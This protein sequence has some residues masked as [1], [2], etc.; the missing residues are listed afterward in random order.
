MM[1]ED[2]KKKTKDVDAIF[3]NELT[4]RCDSGKCNYNVEV[5]EYICGD[6]GTAPYS[7]SKSAIKPLV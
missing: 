3:L 6:P 7:P 4:S 2:A 1:S 5:G